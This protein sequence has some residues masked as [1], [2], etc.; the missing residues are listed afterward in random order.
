MALNRNGWLFLTGIQCNDI[1]PSLAITKGLR[2]M[3]QMLY[4]YQ[5]SL[6]DLLNVVLYVNDMNIFTVLN[7]A[8]IKIINFQKEEFYCF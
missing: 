8:Y 5:Y 4:S 1:D 7:S 2:Q 6:N 3:E